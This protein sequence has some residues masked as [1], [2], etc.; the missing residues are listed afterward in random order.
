MFR[1]TKNFDKRPSAPRVGIA[2]FFGY[3]NY[4]D[5]LFLEVFREHLGKIFELQVLP[6]QLDKPYFSSSVEEAVARQH[7]I[8]IGGGDLVQPWS[9][10]PRYFHS[11]YLNKP[12]FIAGVGVP[13]RAARSTQIEKPHIVER[14]RKFFRHQS[15]RFINARDEQ[16]AD[17][18]NS[19]LE[20]QVG[21][22]SS[23][24]LVCSLTLP[25]VHRDS[26][27]PIFGFVTRHRPN[28][29]ENDNYSRLIELGD[30]ARSL[31]WR[32]RHIILGNGIVGERDFVN[33]ER[34]KIP[35]K[36][37]I[38]TQDIWALTRAVGECST[39]AS[40]KFHGSVVATMYGIPSM[41]LI[42]TS[43]NRNF[44]RRIDREDLLSQFDAENLVE[45]FKPWPEPIDPYWVERL[46]GDATEMLALLRG[47][48]LDQTANTMGGE[49]PS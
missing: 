20:P 47:Q 37:I 7:A 25:Q 39:L 18:I 6:D 2:G 17:W 28:S 44:M 36:E 33:A 32:I 26:G 29:A 40:M 4:G 38:Y 21:V 34:L 8:V 49:G 42:P 48:L 5:E 15:V 16:S 12:I 46:R 31:G 9:I 10:D 3:G 45:R 14:Y 24:D 41:V 27:R 30:Y 43:K 22:I 1:V 23:P 13:I 11:A 19:K 35:D